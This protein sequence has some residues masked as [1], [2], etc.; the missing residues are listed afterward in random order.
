MK[1]LIALVLLLGC[2]VANAMTV[3]LTK[4]GTDGVLAT[5]SGSGKAIPDANNTATVVGDIGNFTNIEVAPTLVTPINF[6]EVINITSLSFDDDGTTGDDFAIFYDTA[7]VLSTDYSIEGASVLLGVNF[8]DLNPGIYIGNASFSAVR[9]GEK[10]TLEVSAVP[11][12]AAV[13]LFGSSLGL[14]GWLR[15][16]AVINQKA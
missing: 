8:S 13:W 12:P 10:I 14:L 2:G 7:V 11:I 15:R 4:H 3:T 1:K 9:L 6:T 5:F 16:K